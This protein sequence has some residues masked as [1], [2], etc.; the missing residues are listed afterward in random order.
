MENGTDKVLVVIMKLDEVKE[1]IRASP[2]MRPRIQEIFETAVKV[3]GHYHS[4]NID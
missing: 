1:I 2:S 3:A 4:A